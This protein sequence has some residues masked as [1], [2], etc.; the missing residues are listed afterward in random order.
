[1]P[2]DPKIAMHAANGPLEG[3]YPIVPAPHA[4]IWWVHHKRPDDGAL[5]VAPKLPRGARPLRYLPASKRLSFAES[6]TRIG[7]RF[8]GL[9]AAYF[10]L[11]FVARGYAE[12]GGGKLPMIWAS[13]TTASGKSASCN[14]IESMWGRTPVDL[15]RFGPDQEERR[16]KAWFAAQLRGGFAT[17]DDFAKFQDSKRGRER[18]ASLVEWLLR[19][20]SPSETEGWVLYDG[21]RMRRIVTP[22]LLTDQD[23]PPIFMENKQLG[24]RIICA[25][26]GGTVPVHWHL[27]GPID[28]WWKDDVEAAP[29]FDTPLGYFRA[30]AESWYSHMTDAYFHADCTSDF[31]AV[32]RSLGFG[33]LDEQAQTEKR[34]NRD[35]LMREL[36]YGVCKAKPDAQA[37]KRSGKGYCEIKPNGNT[38]LARAA[39]DLIRLHGETH[40]SLEVMRRIKAEY[41]SG[42]ENF[43]PAIGPI[44]LEVDANG[45]DIY[46]RFRERGRGYAKKVNAA[47]LKPG[48]DLET[49]L[50]PSPASGA[51]PDDGLRAEGAA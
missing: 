44:S 4:P 50:I 42:L 31:E 11:L 12:R 45:M 29:E 27:L 35:Q 41:D 28:S 26:L 6:E 20:S 21:S 16:D 40:L 15:A 17:F 10:R 43:I 30:A 34:D 22:I 23:T 46:V 14:A 51:V 24:R 49:L 39:M 3:Y 36:F 7:N 2:S 33:T 25:D 38:P 9:N 18:M 47:L 5:H 48:V 37:Q 19:A 1:V 8:P 32:A 13:G